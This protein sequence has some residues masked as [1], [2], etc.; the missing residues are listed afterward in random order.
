MT[1]DYKNLDFSTMPDFMR[2]Q[3]RFH[4]WKMRIRN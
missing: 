1:L 2:K 3:V 4:H